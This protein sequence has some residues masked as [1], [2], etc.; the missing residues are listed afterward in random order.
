MKG[1]SE[2]EHLQVQ[3]DS[4]GPRVAHDA[5]V[6]GSSESIHQTSI[7]ASSLASSVKTTI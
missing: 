3:N 7:T 4:S 6:L 5:L 1:H 2:N